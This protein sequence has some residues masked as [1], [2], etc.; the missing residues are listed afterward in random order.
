MNGKIYNMKG[1]IENVK[2]NQEKREN[3]RIIIIKKNLTLMLV[4]FSK[5]NA[6]GGMNRC[7]SN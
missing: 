6:I 5:D 7:Q 4:G 3:K 1:K 2:Y